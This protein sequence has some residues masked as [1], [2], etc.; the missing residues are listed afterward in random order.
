MSEIHN[1]PRRVWSTLSAAKSFPFP[2]PNLHPQKTFFQT[3]KS[4]TLLNGDR[5]TENLT[6]IL[7]RRSHLAADSLPEI[8][9]VIEIIQRESM[10]VNQADFVLIETALVSGEVLAYRMP[11]LVCKGDTRLVP[12]QVRGFRL[13]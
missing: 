11:K 3:A 1:K 10:D 4:L 6:W 5:C 2:F 9:R 12:L 8:G 7:I 13:L